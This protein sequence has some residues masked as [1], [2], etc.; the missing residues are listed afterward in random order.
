[1]SEVHEAGTEY[2]AEKPDNS[3]LAQARRKLER[4]KG[5]ADEAINAAYSHQS[6][7]NGQPMNDKRGGGRFM[8]KQEQIENR[9]F[10]K[11]DEIKEQEERIERLQEI[12]DRKAAG[13][14]RQGNGLE[15]S[16]QNIPRIRE[17]IEKA[18]RGESS[19]RPE[20]IKRYKKELE[21]LE[22]IQDKVDGLVI[23]PETQALIDSGEVKQW[24]KQPNIYFVKGLRRVALELSEEGR[25]ELSP[26]Y[27]PNTD[28][29]KEIVNKLLSNQKKRE[30]DTQK[31]AL[32]PDNSN[33]SPEDAEWLKKNWNNI[34]F[35]VEPKKQMVI[36]SD[37]TVTFEKPSNPLGDSSRALEENQS[38]EK[39]LGKFQEQNV[40]S[41][42]Q[43]NERTNG[44]QGFLQPKAEGSPTPVPEVGTFE[45]SVTSRP[46][47]SSQYLYFTITY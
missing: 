21:R 45:R 19:Y 13:L 28:E 32:T 17:E 39:A 2:E 16:V 26:K 34:S 6:L 22:A 18:E 4:L 29:E 31:A 27:R 7:T 3:R 30:D 38:T 35:S 8:Q 20:T 25:F 1:M 36:D 15:M 46:T 33:L 12:E 9:V 44:S 23:Q 10:S 41:E 37:K 24:A 11:L 47:L 43:K 5:E 40:N 14:N 42:Y